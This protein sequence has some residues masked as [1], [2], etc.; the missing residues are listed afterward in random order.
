MRLLTL[1]LSLFLFAACQQPADVEQA[2]RPDVYDTYGAAVEETGALP[3]QAVAAE[4]DTY[5]EQN[6]K[7]EGTIVKICQMKGCWLTLDIGDGETVRVM[8][9]RTEAGAYAFTFPMDVSGRRVILDGY[10]EVKTHSVEAQEHLAEDAG[11]TPEEIEAMNLQ[12]K[13]QMW[14][15][16]YGA[17]IEKAEATA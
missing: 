11:K 7:V 10:F 8:V 12:P 1:C 6:V 15:T 14:I 4:P 9:D 17:L 16:A 5:M 2:P 3:I 13:Q